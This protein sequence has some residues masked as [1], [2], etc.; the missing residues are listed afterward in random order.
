MAGMPDIRVDLPEITS[1]EPFTCMASQGV[2]SS[3]K[4]DESARTSI[5]G[6]VTSTAS[7]RSVSSVLVAETDD[8]DLSRPLNPRPDESYCAENSAP[9]ALDHVR[10]SRARPFAQISQCHVTTQPCPPRNGS[11]LRRDP[12]LLSPPLSAIRFEAGAKWHSARRT[13]RSSL[14]GVPADYSKPGWAYQ[15]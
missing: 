9:G 1:A 11:R 13:L 6:P 14:I 3:V 4:L 2:S 15:S 12:R 5:C 10:H 7:A 8:D